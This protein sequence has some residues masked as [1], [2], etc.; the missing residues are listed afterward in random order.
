MNSHDKRLIERL[1]NW[2]RVYP[3]DQYTPE[4]NLYVEAAARIVELS[5]R[6]KQLEVENET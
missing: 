5:K 4:G 6:I 2:E 3:E 1:R